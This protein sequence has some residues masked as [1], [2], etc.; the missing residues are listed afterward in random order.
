MT[1]T[2]WRIDIFE[3]THIFINLPIPAIAYFIN[4]LDSKTFERDFLVGHFW[5]I[6]PS[7]DQRCD[8]YFTILFDQEKKI[9]MKI[10]DKVI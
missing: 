9:Q 1:S 4:T 5:H 8:M 2:S 10:P 3:H 6:W 7:V